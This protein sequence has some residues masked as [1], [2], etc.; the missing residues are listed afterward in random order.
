MKKIFYISLLIALSFSACRGTKSVYNR[1]YVLEIPAAAMDAFPD[2]LTVIEGSCEVLDVEVAMP[3]NAHQIALREES[4]TIRYFSFNEWVQRPAGIFNDML[5]RFLI[6]NNVF[7]ETK[8]GRHA[9]A[10]DY[11]FKTKVHRLE[12]VLINNEFEAYLD[13]EFFLMDLN[14]N[15]HLLHHR[16]KRSRILPE[17]NLNLFAEAIS[18]FFIEELTEFIMR[19]QAERIES[20][21]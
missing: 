7:K 3:Y 12:V 16:A 18:E 10:T 5:L 13:V 8:T 11:A 15:R 1:Y 21:Q 20:E 17:K 6:H 19:M 14:G 9:I 2:Y 4:H